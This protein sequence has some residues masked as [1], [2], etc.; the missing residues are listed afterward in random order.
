MDKYFNKWLTLRTE[1]GADGNN[2]LAASDKL[3]AGWQ[4]PTGGGIGSYPTTC[5]WGKILYGAPKSPIT[6]NGS[7]VGDH[8]YA[9]V[10]VNLAAD[11]YG[12]SAGTYYGL[13][14][15][16]DGITIPTGY[17]T[18]IGKNSKYTDNSLTD[19]Q[20]NALIK[21]GCLFI[22]ASG[23]YST[24]SGYGWRELNSSYHEGHYWTR[25]YYSSSAFYEFKLDDSAG[26]V[27][28]NT[29][30]DPGTSHYYVVKLVRPV[31][32]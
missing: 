14:L 8:A 20:F 5:D 15:F 19:A 26:S 25:T 1:L 30:T 3:P 21:M 13:F 6:V 32:P 31:N 16:R 12:A 7:T 10:T 29:R 17:F 4:F 9:L 18:T 2:I 11:S 28:V 24:Q 23:Y 27:K 22:S